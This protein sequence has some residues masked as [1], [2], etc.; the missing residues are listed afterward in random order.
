MS[1]IDREATDA[2]GDVEIIFRRF[3]RNLKTGETLDARRFGIKA[4][5]IHVRHKQRTS[6]QPIPNDGDPPVE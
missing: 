6:G 4:W 3:R 5:P 2:A 1:R